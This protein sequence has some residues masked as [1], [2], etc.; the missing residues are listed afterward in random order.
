VD[1]SGRGLAV[2]FLTALFRAAGLALIAITLLPRLGRDVPAD[3]F[4]YAGLLGLAGVSLLARGLVRRARL[5]AG[6][7]AMAAVLLALTVLLVACIHRTGGLQSPLVVLLGALVAAGAVLLSPVA[8]FFLLGAACLLLTLMVVATAEGRLPGEAP[9]APVSLLLIELGLIGLAGFVGSALAGRLRALE[10]ELACREL[11]DPG[12]GTLRRSFFHSRLVALL[13][14]LRG[15]R[16]GV[17][18]LLFDLGAVDE[19]LLT[20]A[21]EILQAGVRGDDLAGRVG[22]ARFAV[23]LLAADPETGPHVARRLVAEL[24]RLGTAEVCAGVA[25]LDAAAIGPDAVACARD[26]L[27][28]ARTSL[29]AERVGFAA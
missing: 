29:D 25:H 26:L 8:L 21:G 22:P 10:D 1:R 7:P 4:L 24:Q 3:A 5:A 18:L 20:E 17:S 14:N 27:A 13:E 23:T 9:P 28:A 12:T 11:R 15:G 6:G 16:A 2:F 19:R